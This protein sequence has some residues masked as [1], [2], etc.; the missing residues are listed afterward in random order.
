MRCCKLKFTRRDLLYI[1]IPVR[2][3]TRAARMYFL[4]KVS[5]SFFSA[6]RRRRACLRG[7]FFYCAPRLFFYFF[8]HA[9]Q[10][11]QCCFW[12]EIAGDRAAL[13]ARVNARAHVHIYNIPISA[14]TAAFALGDE[15]RR[16]A[17][18]A[19]IASSAVEARHTHIH[20]RI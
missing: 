1:Y 12:S 9:L 13:A 7:A 5:W 10:Q 3:N 6:D 15:R 11:L 14:A 20:I 2:G 19:M 4:F 8:T 16:R 17:N 18:L